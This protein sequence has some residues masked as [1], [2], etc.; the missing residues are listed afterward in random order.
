MGSYAGCWRTRRRR[1][2]KFGDFSRKRGSLTWSCC[3]RCGRWSDAGRFTRRTTTGTPRP[4]AT[5]SSLEPS[6]ARWGPRLS[7]G[8]DGFSPPQWCVGSAAS[9]ARQ[10]RRAQPELEVLGIQHPLPK[11]KGRLAALKEAGP[12]DVGEKGSAVPFTGREAG[13]ERGEFGTEAGLALRRK[14]GF[15]HRPRR[16]AMTYPRAAADNAPRAPPPPSGRFPRRGPDC[17]PA[18]VTD[19][20]DAPRSFRSS[21][22]R[23]SLVSAGSSGLPARRART[24]SPPRSS[25]SR[26]TCSRVLRTIE[27][28]LAPKR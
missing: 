23:T 13:V 1:T 3:R 8:L 6:G 4:R 28:L 20:S 26:H 5:P 2:G 27:P 15:S 9:P 11:L 7:S 17:T 14:V 24:L 22:S 25:S 21:H 19:S 16:R 10:S 18:A 12:H